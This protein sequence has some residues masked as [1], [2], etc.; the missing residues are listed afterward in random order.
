MKGHLTADNRADSSTTD[1]YLWTYVYF[2]AIDNLT[3][4]I[5]LLL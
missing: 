1:G 2:Y 5:L 4:S 3:S